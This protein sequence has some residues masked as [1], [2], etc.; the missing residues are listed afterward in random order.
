MVINVNKFSF[1]KILDFLLVIRYYEIDFFMLNCKRKLFFKIWF[2]KK[3]K[4]ILFVI[5]MVKLFVL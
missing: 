1:V 2:D 4:V 3:K 5:K